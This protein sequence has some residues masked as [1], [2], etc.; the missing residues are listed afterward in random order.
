MNRTFLWSTVAALVFAVAG[1]ARCRPSEPPRLVGAWRSELQ[2]KTGAF[3]SI[4]NLEYAA[5]GG[6]EAEGRAVR[7]AFQSR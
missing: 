2:F 7:I 1:C 4:K 3:A 6:G 5:E